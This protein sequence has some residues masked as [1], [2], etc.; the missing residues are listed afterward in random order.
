MK[1]NMDQ[2]TFQA[3]LERRGYRAIRFEPQDYGLDAI[4]CGTSGKIEVEKNL[5]LHSGE[6]EQ[7]TYEEARFLID[8]V[9]G[10]EMVHVVHP[11]GHVLL[12]AS[13]HY[14]GDGP[15]A[16]LPHP[17][18]YQV[19]VYDEARPLKRCPNC[20]KPL[21]VNADLPRVEDPDRL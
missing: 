14:E 13:A 8:S 20:K 16:L 11:C 5:M 1:I 6:L 15:F 7:M 12:Y 4:V 3:M 17:A 2:Q 9:Y 19:P 10:D 21:D 18:Y